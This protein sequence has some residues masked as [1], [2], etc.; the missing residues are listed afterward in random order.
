[1]SAALLALRTALLAAH[2]DSIYIAYLAIKKAAADAPDPGSRKVLD[3]I[4]HVLDS[5]YAEEAA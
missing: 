3:A 5:A 2:G 1:L 4:A